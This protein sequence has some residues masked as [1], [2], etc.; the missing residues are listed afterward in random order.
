MREKIVFL[1]NGVVVG[2]KPYPPTNID[3]GTTHAERMEI[4]KGLDFTHYLLYRGHSRRF[5]WGASVD[6]FQEKGNSA[7]FQWLRFD[8]KTY[9]II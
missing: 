1:K 5:Y 2:E 9:K 3:R 6:A 8:K 7:S 4:G